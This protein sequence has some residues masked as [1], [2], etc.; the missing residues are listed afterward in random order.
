MTAPAEQYPFVKRDP[1]LGAASLVPVLPL[2]LVGARTV[3]AAGLLDT[4]AAVNVLPYAV[5][6]QLGPTGNGKP[7]R[8]S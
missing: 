2:S 7:R 1:N 5:G 3:A 6:E 8:S 4:G